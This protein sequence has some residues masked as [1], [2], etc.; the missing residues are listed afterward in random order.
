LGDL[1]SKELK[2]LQFYG[3]GP[4]MAG[5]RTRNK[6]EKVKKTRGRKSKNN[7]DPVIFNSW[8]LKILLY[9]IIILA[10]QVRVQKVRKR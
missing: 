7:I 3:A 1:N 8:S 9:E 2:R 5:F 10:C 4:K 6:E